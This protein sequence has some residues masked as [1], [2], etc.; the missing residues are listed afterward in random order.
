MNIN[1]YVEIE[2][3]YKAREIDKEALKKTVE[4]KFFQIRKVQNHGDSA[5]SHYSCL[6]A[7]SAGI[8][9]ALLAG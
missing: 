9:T 3:L 5:P 4:K 6:I 2:D 1:E 8:F 7:S